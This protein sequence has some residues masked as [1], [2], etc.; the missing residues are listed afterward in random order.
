[1]NSKHLILFSTLFW[2][3]CTQASM[4][5]ADDESNARLAISRLK[6]NRDYLST[7]VSTL[8]ELSSKNRLPKTLEQEAKVVLLQVL[9]ISDGQR[10]TA[11]SKYRAAI[12]LNVL[13]E[14]S[15]E[16]EKVI[17]SGI[18]FRFPLRTGNYR[19]VTESNVIEIMQLRNLSQP[20]FDLLTDV[21]LYAGD[22]QGACT[23]LQKLMARAKEKS[24]IKAWADLK[25]EEWIATAVQL[26][27]HFHKTAHRLR[28][29]GLKGNASRVGTAEAWLKDCN[30]MYETMKLWWPERE[31]RGPTLDVSDTETSAEESVY[32]KL[33]ESNQI[34]V[35]EEGVRNLLK[36]PSLSLDSIQELDRVR[37]E[38]DIETD[39]KEAI[40]KKLREW[41]RPRLTA[42]L[43]NDALE[44]KTP[45]REATHDSVTQCVRFMV[46]SQK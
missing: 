5:L 28:T 26:I 35:V 44:F 31:H 14:T 6:E 4:L 18:R 43:Y 10:S 25:K 39:L 41:L 29:N 33:L 12:A 23:L 27:E 32:R 30:A 7:D 24:E 38:V 45:R 16:L 42:L 46:N 21:A 36:L 9:S 40:K 11:F 22:S 17:L 13:G 15:D 37:S 20:M 19:D 3:L 1:M 34:A 2:L 8:F